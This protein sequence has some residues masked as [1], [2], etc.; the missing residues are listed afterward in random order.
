M[1]LV[2]AMSYLSTQVGALSTIKYAPNEPV[3]AGT[4]YPFA[5][6]YPNSG[7]LEFIPG[8]I[9]KGIHRI[10]L[11]VYFNRSNLPSTFQLLNPMVKEISDLL[12]VDT[13]LGGT[14]DTIV[15]SGSERVTYSTAYVEYGSVNA[16][17]LRFVI[18]VKIR[19]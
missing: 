8:P 13:T 19:E 7:E 10:N 6:V 5:L 11:E 2:S 18:P 14:V 12:L 16:I 1:S 9:F 17:V 15:A 4:A 3:E